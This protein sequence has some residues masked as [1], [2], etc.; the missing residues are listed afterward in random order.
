MISEKFVKAEIYI[1]MVELYSY[2]VT[3]NRACGS[4]NAEEQRQT[5][6][7]ASLER[8]RLINGQNTAVQVSAKL[9]DQT[10]SRRLTYTG[11]ISTLSKHPVF[12][13]N[14]CFNED[15]FVPTT[16]ASSHFSPSG[17]LVNVCLLQRNES[18]QETIEQIFPNSFP[19][20]YIFFYI[21]KSALLCTAITITV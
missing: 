20:F 5:T 12:K 2:G 14:P 9:L 8:C 3:Q 11:G 10:A 6:V 19:V 13:I 4:S 21:F 18:V 16:H 1:S 7:K 17:L 15:D